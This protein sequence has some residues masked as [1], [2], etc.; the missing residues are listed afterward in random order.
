MAQLGHH[1]VPGRVR[2]LASGRDAFQQVGRAQVGGHDDDGVLEVDRA[3]L[4]V[5]DP[6]VVEDLQE[7][8]EHVAV[9]LLDLVEQDD[10]VWLAPHRLG[11][12]TAVL[13]ADV[14]GRRPDQP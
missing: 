6:A 5:G 11:Q 4:G 2:D 10:R 8:I 3:S 13:V 12:L 14:A 1:G 9:R 7:H